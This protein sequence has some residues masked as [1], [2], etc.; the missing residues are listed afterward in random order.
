M[1]ERSFGTLIDAVP[2]TAVP[3]PTTQQLPIKANV[4]ITTSTLLADVISELVAIR[5]LFPSLS[6]S[7]DIPRETLTLARAQLLLLADRLGGKDTPEAYI[8]AAERMG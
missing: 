8:A 1:A 6:V 7:Q 5:A 4:T 2:Y 3:S